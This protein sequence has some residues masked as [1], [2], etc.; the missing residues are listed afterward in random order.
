MGACFTSRSTSSSSKAVSI[1]GKPEAVAIPQEYSA[2]AEKPKMEAAGAVG[3][4]PPELASGQRRL[5]VQVR[6]TYRYKNALLVVSAGSVLD[7]EGDAIVNA[8]NEG[9]ISGGGV[10]GEV[11][12]RGGQAL[13]DAREALPI[14]EGTRSVRCPT[15]E[16]R[17]TIG[18]DL[19]NPYCIHAVGPNYNM[20]MGMGRCSMEDCDNLLLN[21]Y[22]SSMALGEE[23]A[24]KSIG[25]SLLSAG[26]FRGQQSLSKVLAAG[27]HGILQGVYPGLEEVH[28]VAFTK[29]EQRELADVCEALLKDGDASAEGQAAQSPPGVNS[30]A[31]MDEDEAPGEQVFTNEPPPEVAALIRGPAMPAGAAASS[32]PCASAEASPATPSPN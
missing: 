4:I 20:L 3:D 26:I 31:Q 22:R 28:M 15:G 18:G 8:A 30:A 14:V 2:A 6:Q 7:F 9:C 32:P 24:L 13:A 19:K 1:L 10:D 27:V 12:Y 29:Q 16:A 17:I 21:A 23:K 5:G 25:F 11:S